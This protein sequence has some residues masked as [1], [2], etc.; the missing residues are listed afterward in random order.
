MNKNSFIKILSAKLN[1]K[2]NK[3]QSLF[4]FFTGFVSSELINKKNIYLDNFGEFI[5]CRIGTKVKKN[6]KNTNIIIPPRNFILFN[7]HNNLAGNNSGIVTGSSKSANFRLISEISSEFKLT[8]DEAA[9][10]INQIIDMLK[11][12]FLIY[13][14]I[15]FPKFGEFK[16]KR[17]I[18]PDNEE[19]FT[20]KFNPSK[21]IAL[22]VNSDFS[23]LQELK[24]NRIKFPEINYYSHSVQSKQELIQDFSAVRSNSEV[25]NKSADQ[26][27]ETTQFPGERKKIISDELIK[28]HKEIIDSEKKSD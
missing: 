11:E 7:I 18:K 26:H 12:Y 6:K 20:V 1:L 3:C 23:H 25:I 8:I 16:I 27:K 21:K 19:V 28:L 2:K 5:I 9:V 14:K 4:D 17:K 22:K 10:I 13:K 15:E 24:M